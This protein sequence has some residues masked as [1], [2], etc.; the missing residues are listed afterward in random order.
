MIAFKKFDAHHGIKIKQNHADNGRFAN[1]MFIHHC[2]CNC[3]QISYCG[4]NQSPPRSCTKQSLH[5]RSQWPKAI[6][7]ALWPIV[8]RNTV[9]LHNTLP[10]QDGN[11]SC[12]EQFSSINIGTRLANN[13]TSDCLVYQKL[14]SIHHI[15]VIFLI[16]CSFSSI[17]FITTLE[18]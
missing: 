17:T 6:H 4:M 11:R 16:F 5:S 10:T 2:K 12:L 3:Q 1:N 15:T 14:Y 13:H 8:L 18:S 9:H 7:L